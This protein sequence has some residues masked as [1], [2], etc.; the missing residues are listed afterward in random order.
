MRMIIIEILRF[1]KDLLKN[2]EKQVIEKLLPDKVYIKH[3]KFKKRNK[4]RDNHQR[5]N[6]LSLS[7]HLRKFHQKNLSKHQK[8]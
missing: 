2:K 8:K 6:K 1:S 3:Q 7:L 5:K 4:F